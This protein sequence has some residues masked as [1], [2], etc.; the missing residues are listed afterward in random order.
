MT[1]LFVG[2]LATIAFGT[3]GMIAARDLSRAAG[4]GVM[5]SSGT[6]LASAGRRRCGDPQRRALLSDRLDP[7]LRSPVSAGRNS[8]SVDSEADVARG[9]R[10]FR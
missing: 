1:W 4:Y 8:A 6:V 7:G 10:C 9:A 2:G 3:V 5:I